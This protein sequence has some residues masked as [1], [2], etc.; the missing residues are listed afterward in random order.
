MVVR[1]G[2]RLKRYGNL[3]WGD[4]DYTPAKIYEHFG[5][6]K[7]RFSELGISASSYAI[8]VAVS[9]FGYDLHDS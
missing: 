8:S 5:C 3:W 2:Y 7:L 6:T 4:I 1:K 9:L